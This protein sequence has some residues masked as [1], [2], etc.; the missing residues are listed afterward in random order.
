[1]IKKEKYP[2]LIW[3]VMGTIKKGY[4]RNIFEGR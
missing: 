2:C 4:E 1:V 3:S